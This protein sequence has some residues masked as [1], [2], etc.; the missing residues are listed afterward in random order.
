MSNN[1][2]ETF[3]QL[4]TVQQKPKMWLRYVD[5]TVVIWPLGPVRLQEFLDHLNNLRPSIQF[6]ME[7]EYNN[8][9]LFLDVLI[10]RRESSLTTTVYKKHTHTGRYL[11]FRS[12]HPLHV[13]QALVQSLYDRALSNCQEQRNFVTEVQNVKHD[14]WKNGYPKHF[15]DTTINIFEKKN[16]PST[17]SKEACTVVI[18]YV[19]GISDK[20]KRIGNKYNIKTIFKTKHTLRNTG[21]FSN[22]ALQ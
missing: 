6:T 11:L 21:S 10:T 15:V 8:T 7:I 9:L 4:A 1:F 14:L 22:D 12:N 17:Q 20:F 16:Y 18:P 13:K 3:E 19:K 5:D 2:M